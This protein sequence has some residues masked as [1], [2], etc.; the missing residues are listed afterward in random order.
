[1]KW[2]EIKKWAK[3]KGYNVSRE[4]AEDTDE[5]TYVYNWNN[6]DRDAE[7]VAT[8]TKD[9]ATDIY[10]HLTNNKHLAHQLQY[11]K[12]FKI[13]YFPKIG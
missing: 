10:N 13:D 2:S 6:E 4:K 3:A 5:Y 7:G 8:S 12:E 1:M 9:L 11:K